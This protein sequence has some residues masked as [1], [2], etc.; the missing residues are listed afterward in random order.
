MRRLLV[1]LVLLVV[2][3]VCL[4]FYQGW[5][6]VSTHTTDNK[7]NTTITVD[8]DKIHADEEKAKEKVQGLGHAK[9]EK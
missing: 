4:G 2:G 1:V 8:K 5:F 7:V 6:H 3:I 9:V